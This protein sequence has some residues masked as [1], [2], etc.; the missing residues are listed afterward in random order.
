MFTPHRIPALAVCAAVALIGFVDTSASARGFGG[1]FGGR[2]FAGPT[3]RPLARPVGPGLRNW[4]SSQPIHHPPGRNWPGRNS[5]GAQTASPGNAVHTAAGQNVAF[6]GFDRNWPR[7][8]GIPRRW[9]TPVAG[10]NVPPAE[11]STRPPVNGYPGLGT[12]VETSENPPALPPISPCPPDS[13]LVTQPPVATQGAVCVLNQPPTC[14]SYETLMTVA[15]AVAAGVPPVPN[16]PPSGDDLTCAVVGQG[17]WAFSPPICPAGFSIEQPIGVCTHAPSCPVG[18]VLIN[19]AC[20]CGFGMTQ[21]PNGTCLQ[22][23][24]TSPQSRPSGARL[25]SRE[26]PAQPL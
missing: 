11:F 20:E 23:S 3:F 9:P 15:N 2:S 12:V 14:P 10:T 7:H 16:L 19:G 4:M 6:N 26:R 5:G 17:G 8:I 1:V 25:P 13:H 21:Q 22:T 24:P 18:A